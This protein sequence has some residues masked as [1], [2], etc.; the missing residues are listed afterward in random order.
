MKDP[1]ESRSYQS[2][3]SDLCPKREGRYAP[4]YVAPFRFAPS[5]T[6]QK[7]VELWRWT[8]FF[9]VASSM[10][11]TV[12]RRC[13]ALEKYFVILSKLLVL[14]SLAPERAKP[15]RGPGPGQLPRYRG[16]GQL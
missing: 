12:N 1:I 13:D 4:A 8:S 11:E 14:C 15:S 16:L 5:R 6:E 10:K 3:N 7:R 2:G 9:S